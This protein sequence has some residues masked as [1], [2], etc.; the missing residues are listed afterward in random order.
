LQ[1]Q[2]A[3]MRMACGLRRRSF[4]G[5][6]GPQTVQALAADYQAL[7]PGAPLGTRF[8][9]CPD[10][11]L[12]SDDPSERVVAG[13]AVP[14]GDA[15]RIDKKDLLLASLPGGWYAVFEQ[16]G[17][18]RHTWQMWNRV[19]RYSLAANGLTQRKAPRFEVL[20]DD[21][22]Q[23]RPHALRAHL[24]VPVYPADADSAERAQWDERDQ[25]YLPFLRG[26]EGDLFTRLCAIARQA[27]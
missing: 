11:T 13:I 2:R 12:A 5:S 18:L 1:E 26:R 3:L 21:P 22:Q 16:R 4:T 20:Q 27:A 14:K 24:Y 25:D 7:W 15:P 6:V 23:V 10:E 9:L 19:R 17:D 8:V